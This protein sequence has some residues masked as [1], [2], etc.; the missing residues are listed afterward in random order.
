MIIAVM[1]KLV[2]QRKES[3]K[4]F[5]DGG[6][7]DLVAQEQAECDIIVSYLPKQL[8]EDEIKIFVEGVVTNLGA[9]TVKDMGKVMA[10]VRPAL[11]GKAD[12]GLV[13]EVIK[14]RLGGK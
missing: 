14:K 13:G 12:M 6:R 10:E 2:K 7:M 4:S 9:T 11:S 8:T 3:I 1:S 5:T